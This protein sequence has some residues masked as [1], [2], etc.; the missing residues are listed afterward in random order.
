MKESMVYETNKK[1]LVAAIALLAIILSATYAYF[2]SDPNTNVNAEY[3]LTIG[4]GEKITYLLTAGSNLTLSIDPHDLVSGGEAYVEK[5]VSQD[6][7]TL[8]NAGAAPKVI[9]SYKIWY[10]P[11][12][13]F[14]ASSNNTRPDTEFELI[15]TDLS[16]DN[17]QIVF[18]LTNVGTKTLIKTGIIS[19]A[20]LDSAS[21]TWEWTIRHYNLNVDQTEQSGKNYSGNIFFEASRCEEYSQENIL[22]NHIL[23]LESSTDYISSQDGES[24][25]RVKNDNGIRYEGTDP[26][27]YVSIDGMDCRIIGVFD[28]ADIGLESGKYYTKIVINPFSESFFG[29]FDYG[30]VDGEAGNAWETSDIRYMLNQSFNSFSEGIR[31]MAAHATWYLGAMG[32]DYVNY[33]AQDAYLAE[34]GTV[35]A[36]DSPNT[37]SVREYIGLMYPSDIA[38]ARYNTNCDSNTFSLFPLD[39]I[40]SSPTE[41]QQICIM[42][43]WLFT[44]AEIFELLMTS[45]SEYIDPLLLALVSEDEFSQEDFEGFYRDLGNP[46]FH[47]FGGVIVSPLPAGLGMVIP[48]STFFRP[49]VYLES[50]VVYALGDGS[51]ENPYVIL[52]Q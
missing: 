9:C 43:S 48:N 39:L 7:V 6:S 27:N 51:A 44:Q 37:L 46:V 50:D 16:G 36:I 49:V 45:G 52:P 23:A 41:E 8:D 19:A 13:Y 2:T 34:R 32:P 3:D 38:Y 12:D 47:S 20:S 14:K 25:Y 35:G 22:S 30:L 21:Q 29:S 28:G 31:Q 1:G 18:D 24:I 11:E 42:S 40:G 17:S 4:N 26:D 15:G 33:T 10:E 5:T